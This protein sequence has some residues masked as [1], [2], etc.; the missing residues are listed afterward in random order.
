[1]LLQALVKKMAE[2]IFAEVSA[3]CDRNPLTLRPLADFAASL[4]TDHVIRIYTTN[5]DDFLLQAVP[6]LYTGFAATP[7]T[8]PKRFES[9]QFWYK[10]D[11]AS[12][13]HLHGSVHMGFATPHVIN[14]DVG[15]LFWFDDRATALKPRFPASGTRASLRM[16]GSSYV[17]S[18]VVTG[19]D[20]LSLLQQRPLSDFYSA[21]ARDAMLADLRDRDRIRPRR[22]SPQ[23]LAGRGALA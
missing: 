23:H 5:Y 1:M 12:A 2:D 3:A 17:P 13:F 22:S 8:A 6:D 11:Q 9:D 18:A 19:L 4:R 20:K 16:D 15:E 21:L 10:D 7:S 14:G